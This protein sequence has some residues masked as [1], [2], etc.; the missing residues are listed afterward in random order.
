MNIQCLERGNSYCL[1]VV[2]ALCLPEIVDLDFALEH[3]LR[4]D[5]VGQS[6]RSLG[7]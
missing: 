7:T 4:N 6:M 2:E 1:L 5:A 3:H